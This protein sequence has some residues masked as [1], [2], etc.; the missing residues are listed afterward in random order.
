[1]RAPDIETSTVGSGRMLGDLNQDGLSGFLA[2]LA[3]D[4]RERLLAEAVRIYVPAGVLVY[5]A[6]ERPRVVIVI[7][8]LL[9]IFLSSSEGRQTT[10]RYVRSGDVAGLALVV[11][12]PGP[13]SIQAMTAATVAAL[14]VDTLRLLLATDPGVARACAEEL[15]RQLYRAFDEISEQAFLS[16]RQRVIH[17]LLDLASPGAGPT[18]VVHAS[19]QD[20][21]DAVGSVREVVTRTLGELRGEGLIE[22][23]RDVIVLR[24]P[25]KLAEDPQLP[26]S[27]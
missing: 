23:S 11:G 22:T 20:V 5:R 8:G 2:T 16:V 4:V 10:V 17:Q 15:T 1:M 9:R 25:I 24:D 19:Q 13:M 26:R 27:R 12:G 7:H 21:A 18:L 3:S 14:R 6:D